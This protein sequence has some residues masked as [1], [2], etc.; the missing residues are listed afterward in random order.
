MEE[1]SYYLSFAITFL[2]CVLAILY[3]KQKF[4]K[5]IWSIKKAKN[6]YSTIALVIGV[7]GGTLIFHGLVWLFSLFGSKSSFGH[8]EILIAA[9]LYNFILGLVLIGVGRIIIGWRKLS[10]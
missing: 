5:N 2:L 3:S 8:G 9:I 10:W 7:C 1:L 4:I 6:V